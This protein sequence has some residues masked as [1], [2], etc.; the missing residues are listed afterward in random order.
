MICKRKV[1]ML[2][3][4]IYSI[5]TFCSFRWSE[6]DSAT[7][8]RRVCAREL[9]RSAILTTL[10]PDMILLN[11]FWKW[12]SGRLETTRFMFIIAG[13]SW[14]MAIIR[15]SATHANNTD[16]T[17]IVLRALFQRQTVIGFISTIMCIHFISFLLSFLCRARDLC[18]LGHQYFDTAVVWKHCICSGLVLVE[19]RMISWSFI[20]RKCEWI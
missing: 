19:V 8:V 14:V 5:I 6:S 15:P 7:W 12:F 17:H 16:I 2:M 4:I 1:M 10:R 3:G 11:M 18:L 20:A 9:P 13:I